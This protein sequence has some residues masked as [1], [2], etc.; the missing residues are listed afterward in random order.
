MTLHV[1]NPNS[2]VEV[3]QG[4]E[5]RGQ[6]DLSTKVFDIQNQEFSKKEYIFMEFGWRYETVGHQTTHESKDNNDLKVATKA[7]S[8]HQ[9]EFD[10]FGYNAG[11]YR[12]NA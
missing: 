8:T 3:T 2:L 10:F 9:D 12:L 4:T 11:S 7:S 6:L 1:I 5:C